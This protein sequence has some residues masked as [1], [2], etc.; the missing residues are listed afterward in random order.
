MKI[1]FFL[2]ITAVFGIKHAYGSLKDTNRARR[3]I[4]VAPVTWDSKL[5]ASAY[6]VSKSLSDA[7]CALKHSGKRGVGENL[8][9]NGGISYFSF[10]NAVNLWFKERF[11]WKRGI[12][13][14][15]TQLVWKDT[16]K[17]GCAKSVNHRKKCEIV[18]CHYWPQGNIIGRSPF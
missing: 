3:I 4:G 12:L 7:G 9:M 10:R 2:L 11:S 18:T 14:H 17:I 16:R 8:Y 15:F 1:I 6:A 5:A 13:N